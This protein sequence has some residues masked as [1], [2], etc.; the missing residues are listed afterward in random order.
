MHADVLLVSTPFATL[1]A[2]SLGLSLLR[3]CLRS[4]GIKSE[5][6]YFGFDFAQLIGPPLYH[7]IASYQPRMECFA[8]EWVFST[9]ETESDNPY[10]DRI[11]LPALD[12]EAPAHKSFL[13]GL[14]KARECAPS[15]IARCA[16]IVHERGPRIV[17]FTSMFQQTCASLA[18]ASAVKASSPDTFIAF[19]GSNC[20]GV[21]GP[22]LRD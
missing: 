7:D 9:R 15:Y 12:E 10:L 5:I 19:G 20:E 2:P 3:E 13:D 16:R 14:L 17:G 11:L 18:L 6:L 21:M 4:A 8:G 1:H 22:A